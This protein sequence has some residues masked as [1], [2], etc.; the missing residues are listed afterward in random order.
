MLLEQEYGTTLDPEYGTLVEDGNQIVCDSC[1]LQPGTY[2]IHEYMIQSTIIVFFVGG[3]VNS[4]GC[5]TYTKQCTCNRPK[6][7]RTYCT[8]NQ[9][10]TLQGTASASCALVG[11]YSTGTSY[12]TMP[13]NMCPSAQPICLAI[14]DQTK[15][16]CTCL[17]SGEPVLQS[18]RSVDIN[19]RYLSNPSRSNHH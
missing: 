6:T 16:I 9:E 13:C 12:G 3:V 7:E 17:Q 15:G 10:C 5:D 1:P 14:K 18:C 19:S 8:S 2:Y 11:D 4:F